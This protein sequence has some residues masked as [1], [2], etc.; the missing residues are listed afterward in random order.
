[1][2]VNKLKKVVFPAPFGPIIPMISPPSIDMLTPETAYTPPKD[3]DRLLTLIM[4]T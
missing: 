3:L 2:P 4:G 1:M